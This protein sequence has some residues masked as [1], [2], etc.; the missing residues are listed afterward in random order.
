MNS[1]VGNGFLPGTFSFV[2]VRATQASVSKT[3]VRITRAALA[4][5]DRSL[6]FEQDEVGS[7]ADLRTVGQSPPI[8]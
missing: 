7:P 6:S 8:A 2:T 5:T 3:P 4:W 1:P